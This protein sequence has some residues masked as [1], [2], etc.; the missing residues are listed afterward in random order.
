MASEYLLA[1]SA[2]PHKPFIDFLMT[3]WVYIPLGTSKNSIA[4]RAA[5]NLFGN[6]NK[7]PHA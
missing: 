5:S 7:N 3:K 1:R 4:E 2:S 6:S